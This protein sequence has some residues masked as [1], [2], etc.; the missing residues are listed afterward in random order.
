[1][2]D[3]LYLNGKSLLQETF[4]HRRSLIY[5]HFPQVKNKLVWAEKLDTDNFEEI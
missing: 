4:E 5:K 2:F 1:M 3:L